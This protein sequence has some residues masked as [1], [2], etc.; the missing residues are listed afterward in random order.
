MSNRTVDEDQQ[1][2]TTTTV[3]A[4]V[5]TVS[6]KGGWVSNIVVSRYIIYIHKFISRHIK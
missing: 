3:A 5:A 6:G 1:F 2:A 4:I